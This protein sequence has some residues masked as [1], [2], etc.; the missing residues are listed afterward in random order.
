MKSRLLAAL[1]A[2]ACLGAV[3]TPAPTSSAAGVA[4]CTPPSGVTT[5]TWTGGSGS[6]SDT[7][8]WVGGVRPGR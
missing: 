2:V 1:V 3:L 8:H 5:Y 7:S 6:W 4:A